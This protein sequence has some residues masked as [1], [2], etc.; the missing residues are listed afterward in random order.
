MFL[1]QE[2]AFETNPP[3]TA[4]E[5]NSAAAGFGRAQDLILLTG[6]NAGGREGGRMLGWCGS[7]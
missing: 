6:L 3:G 7:F 5:G 4:S 2:A 1:L